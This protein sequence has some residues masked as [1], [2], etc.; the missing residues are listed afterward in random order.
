M[1]RP[2][3]RSV[4]ATPVGSIYLCTG[5]GMKLHYYSK[6]KDVS[7]LFCYSKFASVACSIVYI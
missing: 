4:P 1:N 6:P 3:A 7:K 2:R 5:A